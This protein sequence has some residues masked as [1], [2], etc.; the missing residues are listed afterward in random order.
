MV[1]AIPPSVIHALENIHFLCM[2]V[3]KFK[4]E[5]LPFFDFEL[6]NDP[7]FRALFC[8]KPFPVSG[9]HPKPPLLLP[10]ESLLHV[11]SLL[12]MMQAEDLTRKNGYRRVVYPCFWALT[13]YLSHCH[14]PDSDPISLQMERLL[15]VVAYM[16]EHLNQPLRIQELA[17]LIFLSTRQ[18]DRLF[19]QVYCVT[20]AAYLLD[21][22]LSQSC[23]LMM[24]RHLTLDTIQMQCGF[25]NYSHFC[26]CFKKRYGQTPT[27][28]R[29]Q[30]LE[31]LCEQ[32][33]ADKS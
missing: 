1:L 25:S 16:E 22:R 4:M 11:I 19:R 8:G 28:Y 6:R 13:A 32:M 20:P 31:T 10:E 7:G 12:E 30:L 23:K 26:R 29:T 21:L 18:F 15:P 5:C 2:Y 3:L 24:D 27:Q 9:A 14:L 17:D 33:D